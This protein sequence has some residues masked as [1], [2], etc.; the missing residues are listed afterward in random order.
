MHILC[1]ND[2]C[3]CAVI[4]RQMH[5][6]LSFSLY[7]AQSILKQKFSDYHFDVAAAAT[8]FYFVCFSSIYFFLYLDKCKRNQSCSRLD[9]HFGLFAFR[10]QIVQVGMK[11]GKNIK[12]ESL[13]AIIVFGSIQWI[14]SGLYCTFVKRNVV[15]TL[16]LMKKNVYF[17]CFNGQRQW[18]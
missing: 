11:R 2:V 6:F 15:F 16:L 8:I 4:N 14:K 7:S 17:C 3:V 9:N 12:A 13:I 1:I 10:L 5:S 18:I